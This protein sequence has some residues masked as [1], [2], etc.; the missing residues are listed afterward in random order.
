MKNVVTTEP[1][2]VVEVECKR[3]LASRA[4]EATDGQEYRHP[5]ANE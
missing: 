3:V 5:T 2:V 1:V 4:V